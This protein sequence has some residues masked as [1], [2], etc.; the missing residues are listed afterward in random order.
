MPLT[1]S[2]SPHIHS[3]ASTRRVMIDV[4]IA[5]SP[6][7]VASAVLF[8]LRA[9]LVLLVTVAAAIGAEAL[10][11]IATKKPQT[12][13]DCSAAVTGVI[14]ALNLPYTVP[15]WQAAIGGGVATAFVKMLFGGIGKNFA[16]PA[17]TARVILLVSFTEISV[18]TVTR[19]Q[20]VD[21]VSSP[22]PLQLL[23]SGGVTDALPSLADMLV[24]NRG[25]AMGE[26]CIVAI[27]LG[28]VYLIVRRVISLHTPVAFVG[29][30]FLFTLAVTQSPLYALYA[31]LS[32]GLIFAAVFMATDYATTPI[33]RMGQIV[34]GIGCGVI[35]SVIRL[36]G[37][38]PDGVSYAILLMNILTPYVD[39]LSVRFLHPFGGKK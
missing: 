14:L 9:L 26:T 13:S 27:L 11:C 20:A 7:V 12:V 15:L 6:A 38:L 19:F 10:F 3:G 23:A 28:A 4:L 39:R 1:L 8:S 31:I 37:S 17:A 34:F 16:N 35:T 24:G 2:S 32:G 36:F 25:G 22:T 29:S 18:S 33:T 5:L 30:V 21:G